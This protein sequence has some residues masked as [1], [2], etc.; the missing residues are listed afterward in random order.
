MGALCSTLT[1]KAV[2]AVVA[3]APELV[4]KVDVSGS[5][6]VQLS[7]NLAALKQDVE[8]LA[9]QTQAALLDDAAEKMKEA[10][11]AVTA[12]AVLSPTGTTSV[13]VTVDTD[14][15]GVTVSV[16]VPVVD[17][18]GTLLNLLASNVPRDIQNYKEATGITAK[19]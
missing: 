5:D 4:P 2:V 15:S 9:K 1:N 13:P 18:S 12:A 8:G 11:A 17:A 19:E 14:V 16:P 7:T 6:L 3:A 10:A